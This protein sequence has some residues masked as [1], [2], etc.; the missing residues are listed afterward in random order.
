MRLLVERVVLHEVCEAGKAL[1]SDLVRLE[2]DATVLLD[3]HVL[4]LH[5]NDVAELHLERDHAEKPT[6]FKAGVEKRA[7]AYLAVAVL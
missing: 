1:A 3:Q 7:E 5:A 4:V 6:L 2:H